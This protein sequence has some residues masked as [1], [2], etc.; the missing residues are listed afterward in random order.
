M[1]REKKTSPGKKN[2]A[3]QKYEHAGFLIRLVAYILDS[4]IIGLGSLF[5]GLCIGLVYGVYQ[6]LGLTPPLV[7]FWLGVLDILIPLLYF[8]LFH[9]SMWQATP[10]K[11]L[12]G[13]MVTDMNYKRITPERAV[14]R[15]L[16]RILCVLTFGLGYVLIA[17]H[18]KKQGLHDIVAGTF[19]VHG[20]PDGGS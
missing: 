8:S 5:L 12:V 17:F 13:I 9:S 6:G 19:V 16:A 14:V 10:G 1:P 2:P 3:S 4:I 11:R 7:E 18:D 15:W 20:R